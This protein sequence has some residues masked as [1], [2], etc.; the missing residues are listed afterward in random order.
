MEEDNK[1]GRSPIITRSLM[2]K[3]LEKD[4]L[5]NDDNNKDIKGM[6]E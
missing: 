3:R 2:R 6:S 5:Q 1:R 4:V